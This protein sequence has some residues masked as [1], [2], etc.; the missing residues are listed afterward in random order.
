MPVQWEGA[1]ASRLAAPRT[2]ASAAAG[3][4]GHSV[5]D[6]PADVAPEI[7][8]RRPSKPPATKESV[9]TAAVMLARA[10]AWYVA[11]CLRRV[12]FAVVRPM[13]GRL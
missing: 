13:G 10:S 8:V 5:D 11:C 4:R 3:G 12:L 7:I 1:G 2:A 9:L 6:H